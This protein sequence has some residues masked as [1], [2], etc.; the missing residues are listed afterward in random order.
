M[1]SRSRPPVPAHPLPWLL[2]GLLVVTGTSC[3]V[4]DDDDDATAADDDDDDTGDDDSAA[5]PTPTITIVQ[6]AD[7][8]AFDECA[9]ICFEAIVE[10][11]GA[12]LSD[13]DAAVEVEGV[14]VIHE[15]TTDEAGRVMV[16]VDGLP[17]GARAA[18]FTVRWQG[19]KLRAETALELH[20]FGWAQ[21]LDKPLEALDELPWLPYANKHGGNPLLGPGVPGSWDEAGVLLPAVVEDGGGYRMYYAGTQTGDYEIGLATSPDGIAWTRA[22]ENPIVPATGEAGSWK[23]WSTNAP[24]VVLDGGSTRMWYAGRAEE[25]SD[26]AIGYAES[27]D[28]VTFVDDPANPVLSAD[29]GEEGDSLGHPSVVVR[30]GWVEM[31]YSTAA[32]DIRY[33]LSADGVTWTRYCHNPV[34]E[35]SSGSWE[36]GQVKSAEVWFDGQVYWASYAGGS[37]GG[38]Q[39]GW[40]ASAD[41]LRWIKHEEPWI[42]KGDPGSWEGTST[43]GA[44]MLPDGDDLRIWYAGTSADGGQIGYA[45]AQGVPR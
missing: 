36:G 5:G 9:S 37:S 22:P 15:G 41:G 33:A 27:T 30:Q 24:A 8:E 1:V 23:R 26:I 12:A 3:P 2:L 34:L 14:G 38:F 29:G 11:D 25:L 35:G 10:Q 42:A 21:G 4:D 31:W 28:G 6:P 40:A 16:C 20:P 13:L 39:T 43:L 45:E 44:V 18:A 32:H 19:D 7:G 17:A